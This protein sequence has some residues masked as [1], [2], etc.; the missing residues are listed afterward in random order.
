MKKALV[1]W[2][3]TVLVA[4]DGAVG[5]VLNAMRSKESMAVFHHLGYPDYFATM[6]GIAKVLGAV[7]IVLPVPRVLREWAYAGLTFDVTAALISI[8]AVGDPIKNTILPIVF[9][10]LTLTSYIAW[11]RRA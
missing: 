10:V 2:I 9:I 4:L 5:G 7:A 3:P 11:K 8:L 6:L 1:Y